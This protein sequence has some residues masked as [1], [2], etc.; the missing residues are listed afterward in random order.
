MTARRTRTLVGL[1]DQL[2]YSL[3]NFLLAILVAHHSTPAGFGRYSILVATFLIAS[4]V[5]RG[6]TSEPLVVRFSTADRPAWARAA[7]EG[8]TLATGFGVVAGLVLFTLALV[9]L[10]AAFTSM[11]AAFSVAM[12]A[13]F[14]QDFLRYAALAVGRPGA[15]LTNDMC[16]AAVQIAISVALAATGQAGAVTFVLAWAAGG[17][18]GAGVGTAV[19]RV[20]LTLPNARAVFGHRDL[21]ARLGADNFVAQLVQQSTGYLVAAVSGLAAAGGLRAAQ[22]VFTPPAILSLGAQ[23]ALTPEFVRLQSTSLA[24]MRRA[25]RALTTGLVGF[26]SVFLA[27]A[28]VCP[29]SLGVDLFG[30]SWAQAKPL[31]LFIGLAMIPGSG[32]SIP[33]IVALRALGDARRTL[34]ARTLANLL[35]LVAVATG[36]FVGEAK[37]ACIGLSIASTAQAV[38]WR[39]Q[40]AASFR[41]RRAQISAGRP[42]ASIPLGPAAPA[43]AA[44]TVVA[45]SAGLGEVEVPVGRHR[46]SARPRPTKPPGGTGH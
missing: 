15:A 45:T 44:P 37:G 26:S 31:L 4:A 6:L 22:T 27:A 1:A 16:V 33:A 46:S 21:A 40:V 36:A 34:R 12:P 24:S 35:T 3:T 30:A 41:E 23:S 7:T 25:M 10:P 19:L 28:L 17:L 8:L 32:V 29:N 11:A 14:A 39:V 43:P 18:V 9:L 20:R 5:N 13:L 42:A 2:L 38:I